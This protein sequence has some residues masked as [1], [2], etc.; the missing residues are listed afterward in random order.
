MV[1]KGKSTWTSSSTD[2]DNMIN[3]IFL[4]IHPKTIRAIPA[5]RNIPHELFPIASR[6]IAPTMHRA[7]PP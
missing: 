7:P 1:Q 2:V 4:I 6:K 3:Y 5:K